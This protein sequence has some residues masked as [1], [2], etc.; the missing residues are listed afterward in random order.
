[1]YQ[2]DPTGRLAP[3]SLDV[4]RAAA[5]RHAHLSILRQPHGQTSPL[6]ARGRHQWRLLSF[7]RS[8][9]EGRGPELT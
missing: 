8:A 5:I 3:S 1:M 7:A 6:P 9:L 2:L 4:S